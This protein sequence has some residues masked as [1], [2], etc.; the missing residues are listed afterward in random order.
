MLQPANQRP[1]NIHVA[2]VFIC[3]QDHKLVPD[4]QPHTLSLQDIHQHTMHDQLYKADPQI[5]AVWAKGW[6]HAR[7]VTPPVP[8][9]GAYRIEVGL[10]DHVRRYIFDAPS[11]AV[12]QLADR[13][14]EP[15]VFIKVCAPPD[16]VRTLLPSNWV[17]QSPAYMMTALEGMTPVNVPLPEGYTL[18]TT[19]NPGVSI[20]RILAANGE[21]A[22]IGRVGFVED[23]AIYDRIATHENH[24]RRKLGTIIMKELE[25]IGNARGIK[26]GLLVATD[27]GRA[28]YETIGWKMHS[29]YCTAE[30]PASS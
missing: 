25:A 13:I 20:V 8:D 23:F 18:H 5:V 17:L 2:P 10:P 1:V 28:L 12:R 19:E 6:A 11:S 7:E 22:A 4:F 24:R 14:T 16:V 3:V 30:I 26:K 21:E 29:L 15:Y 27:D 9:S